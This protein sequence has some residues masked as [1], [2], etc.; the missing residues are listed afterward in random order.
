MADHN[1]NLASSPEPE[2]RGDNDQNIENEMSAAD[3]VIKVC[4]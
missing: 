3:L 4:L 1:R 2:N